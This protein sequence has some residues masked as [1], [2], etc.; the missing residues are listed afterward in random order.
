MAVCV[1]LNNCVPFP[2]LV[3]FFRLSPDTVAAP[4]TLQARQ[5]YPTDASSPAQRPC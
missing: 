4:Q 3:M 1:L 2:D 5:C